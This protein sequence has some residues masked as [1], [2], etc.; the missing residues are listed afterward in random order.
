MS[1][2]PPGRQPNGAP[3]PNA[4]NQPTTRPNRPK[5]KS[6]I[7][8]PKRTAKPSRPPGAAPKPPPPPPK[9]KTLEQRRKENNGWSE[10]PPE[11]CENL[12]DIPIMT[13]KKELMKNLTHHMMKLASTKQ[14]A[15]HDPT[16]V[17]EFARPVQLH[18][19]NPLKAPAARA[20]KAEE[21]VEKKPVDAEEA[22][23]LEKLKEEKEAQKALDQAKIA[24]VAKE[25]AKQKK[26]KKQDKLQQRSIR[27][28]KQKN[29]Q[30]LKYQETWPWFLED[31]DGTNV[32]QSSY[33]KAHS[34]THV[35]FKIDGSVFRMIPVEKWYKFDFKPAGYKT[36]TTEE[37][38]A[39]MG[40]KMDVGR[41]AMKNQ[42]LAAQQ[43]E[44]DAT[45]GFLGAGKRMIKTESSTFRSANRADKMDHDELDVSGDEFQDDDEAHT[46]ERNNLDEDE[47]ES[48]DRIRREQLGANTFG[49]GDELELEKE[50]ERELKE[51]EQ[52]KAWGK[53]TKKALIKRDRDQQYESSSGEERDPF[54][55]SVSA[56]GWH[57]ETEANRLRMKKG[58]P[59]PNRTRRTQMTK[60]K[61]RRRKMRP[62]A[63]R[64]RPRTRRRANPASRALLPR[65]T[66]LSTPLRRAKARSRVSSAQVRPLSRSLAA[67]SRRGKQSSP[68]RPPPRI[69][70]LARRWRLASARPKA[71]GLVVTERRQL[72]R[73]RTVLV[74][75]RKSSSRAAAARVRQLALA[76]VARTLLMPVSHA[77]LSL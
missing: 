33:I 63:V 1:A 6:S 61:R 56:C 52:R 60:R 66:S 57:H 75:R 16:D 53:S 3:K 34:N 27:S 30:E 11:G 14:D 35:A 51:E 70:G 22:E 8:A 32:W 72:V 47:K 67:T 29:Q 74:P 38:E 37:A 41:W 9:K 26:S 5:T 55:D 54:K 20:V 73:C 40:K 59:N 44:M 24:P 18:R 2:P 64:P 46:F 21:E 65:K 19:R 71:P 58:H 31:A 69:A 12:Q 7:F 43:A 77:K 76:P 4:G 50:L 15:N 23:R 10:P 49:A 68:R 39:L 36:Y 28:E 62:A 42:G 13:T 45:R 25:K 48:K 17:D